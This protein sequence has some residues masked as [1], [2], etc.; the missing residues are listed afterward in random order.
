[1]PFPSPGDL[2]DPG[3]EPRSSELQADSLPSEPPGKHLWRQITCG[4]K[5]KEKEEEDEKDLLVPISS[6][7]GLFKC[8]CFLLTLG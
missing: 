8:L 7:Y 6:S 3:M 2:P 4:E 5:Q 1:M